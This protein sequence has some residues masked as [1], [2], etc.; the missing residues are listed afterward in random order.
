M[1]SRDPFAPGSISLRL[2]PHNELGAGGIVREL[3]DQARLALSMGFD[4][5]MTSE[6]HGGFAGYLPNP[7]QVSGFILDSTPSGWVAPC[8]LLLPLRPIGQ[9]AEEIA[10]L[11]AR[12]PG[13][14]G[15]GVA[16][17][18]L[19]LDFEAMG[20]PFADA[21]PLFKERLP[22]IVQMLQGRDLRELEH[23][24]ALRECAEAPVPVLSAAS[25]RT[26]ARRAA[27]CGAGILT[28]GMSGVPQLKRICD[29]YEASGG[30]RPKV[31]VRRIWLGAP[32]DALIRRQRAVYDTYA[33]DS[34]RFAED[35][36]VAA[37]DGDEMVERL[38]AIWQSTGADAVNLRVHLPGMAAV[39]VRRQIEVLAEQVLP[40]LRAR[41][42]AG[43]ASAEAQ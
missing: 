38:S 21:V 29:A 22:R 36:T 25:S 35:Q 31:I 20:V 1:N 16:A 30:A 10:W 11:G 32:R 3:C 18:A 23:D 33:G 17:G 34:G 13:R 37:D 41:W 19:P 42:R 9:L 4:G 28:E 8:P 43:N 14:V 6:H 27:T 2:Y 26:A 12:H 7:L 24:P 39:E 5:I 40:S 15:L